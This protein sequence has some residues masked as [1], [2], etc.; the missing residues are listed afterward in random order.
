MTGSSKIVSFCSH[1]MGA[2]GGLGRGVASSSFQDRSGCGG[3]KDRSRKTSWETF[4]IIQG[5]RAG[6]GPG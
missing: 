5:K 3:S 2:M 6:C 4:V 1:E